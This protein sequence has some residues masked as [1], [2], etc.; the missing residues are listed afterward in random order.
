MQQQTTAATWMQPIWLPPIMCG[1]TTISPQNL[2]L[3]RWR[4]ALSVPNFSIFSRFFL[5]GIFILFLSIPNFPLAP[6]QKPGTKIVSFSPLNPQVEGKMEYG[7]PF[8]FIYYFLRYLFLFFTLPISALDSHVVWLRSKTMLKRAS[9]ESRLLASP[10]LIIRIESL[11][12]KPIF[13]LLL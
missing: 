7:I 4:D 10:N 13:N 11:Y 3:Q 12:G 5:Y 6:T 9:A 1:D 8:I 2:V